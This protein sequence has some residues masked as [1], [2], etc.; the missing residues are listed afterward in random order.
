MQLS[1]ARVSLEISEP[2][3][4]SRTLLARILRPI[5]E[6]GGTQHYLLKSEDDDRYLIIGPRYEDDRFED[7]LKGVEVSVG[8][9]LVKDTSLLESGEFKPDQIEYVWI[10]GIRLANDP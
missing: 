8:I 10:G 7:V 4:A 5:T 6:L 3:D 2:W 9:A 1:G